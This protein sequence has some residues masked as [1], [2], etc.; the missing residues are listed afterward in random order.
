VLARVADR[1]RRGQRG[2][3]VVEYA[4]VLLVVALIIGAVTSIGLPTAI[5]GDIKCAVQRIELNACASGPDAAAASGALGAASAQTPG[6]AG[7]ALGNAEAQ[8]LGSNTLIDACAGGTTPS[9]T[10]EQTAP[11][12]KACRQQ[13]AKLGPHSLAVL[14]LLAAMIQAQQPGNAGSFGLLLESYL[15]HP[16]WAVIALSPRAQAEQASGYTLQQK[17]LHSPGDLWDGF[18]G[19]LCGGYG[20]CLGGDANTQAY[21][22]AWHESA[23]LGRISTPIL[24]ATGIGGLLKDVAGAGLKTLLAKL[25]SGQATQVQEAL[26]ELESAAKAEGPAGG[27]NVLAL[28]PGEPELTQSALDHIV[29]RHFPASD[30]ANAGKF[31]DGTT[32]QQVKSMIR[33]AVQNGKF[34]PNTNGR[35]GTICEYDF[36]RTIGV[37]R[38]GNP[39][40]TLRVVIG[41]DGQVITAFPY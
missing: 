17:L 10:A 23:Q 7:A 31:A 28:P 5:A 32:G 27:G 24:V 34:R 6:V 21:Q 9:V 18:F 12:S 25:S 19:S 36:G 33:E 41:P 40:S 30:A 39:T 26:G 16:G 15:Q 29:A 2:Q 1:V 3:D 38:T 35:P 8:A 4:G 37:S 14:A 20:I 22:Q 11:D 13:L